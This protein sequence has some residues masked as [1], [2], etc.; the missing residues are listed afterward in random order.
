ME[1]IQESE[2]ELIGE[3]N[4]SQVF[5]VRGTSLVVKVP[6]EGAEV[7]QEVER[8]IYDRLGSHATLLNYRG[9]AK[10]VIS[11]SKEVGLLFDYCKG[12]TLHKVLEDQTLLS[13]LSQFRS[14]WVSIFCLKLY[15]HNCHILTKFHRWCMQLA[16]ALAF[17]HYKGIIHGDFGTHNILLD[18]NGSAKVID[19]GGSRLDGSRCLSF[20]SAR[21]R[22]D[23]SWLEEAYEPE[24]KD[25]IFALGMVLCE[26][27]NGRHAYRGLT[28]TEVL[29][30][31]RQGRFPDLDNISAPGM[32][33]IVHNCL[34]GNY[35]D[36]H[37]VVKGLEDLEP[38]STPVIF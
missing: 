11:T 30:H 34:Q 17:I 28:Y 31:V 4:H 27:H 5:L 22:R 24:A 7:Q 8:Q 33:E 16:Q 10:V 18:K 9:R 20:P 1:D 32:K 35:E 26:I 14:E 6:A 13:R 21:Y 19:F 3:G 29:D 38:A 37:D 23:P 25:D 15:S 36:V 12:D 2:L